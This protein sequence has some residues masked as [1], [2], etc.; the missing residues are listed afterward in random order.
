[1]ARTGPGP[2]LRSQWLGER[3]RDIRKRL[4]IPQ[5]DAASHI[6]KN[7]S[8]LGRYESGEIP[9]R[10]N[11]VVDLLDYYGIS[12]EVERDG[13]LQLCE[14]IWRKHWWDQHRD[15][16]GKDFINVPWLESRVDRNC[17]YQHI[18]VHGLLQT[19]EY[20]EALIRND[21]PERTPETQIARWIDVRMERQQ[22]LHKEDP[23]K[24]SVVMEELVLQRPV[25]NDAIRRAQL[26]HLLELSELENIEV[27]VLPT[28]HGPHAA[29][30][31]SFNLYEM[32]HP[33]PD[34]AHVETVG[35]SLYIEEPT[36]SRVREVWKDLIE[37]A[38]SPE[39]TNALVKRY[40][41]G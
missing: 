2:S 21:A 28:A 15:D 23:A 7:S 41:E 19:R 4:R 9:F 39:E 13:L 26:L 25:G 30:H 34:V 32:P 16:L 10:R 35:G 29:H 38:L 37:S 3:M 1:M 24:L 31:G 14:D 22:V 5:Q 18:I 33:Y 17:A 20:A 6:Q 40:L 11:D 36:V 12:N 27:R 8:M